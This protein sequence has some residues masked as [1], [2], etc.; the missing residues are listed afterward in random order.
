[1]KEGWT[2]KKLGDCIDKIPK[3]KQ[4]KSKDYKAN[5]L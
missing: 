5:G 3:Q 1:M 4:V 2:Y